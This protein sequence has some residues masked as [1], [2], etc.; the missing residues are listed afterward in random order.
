MTP[1][2]S[3]VIL[4]IVTTAGVGLAGT[5]IVAALP[6]SRPVVAAIAAPFV[7]VASLAAGVAVATRQMLI[8]DHTSQTLLIVLAA[9]APLALLVGLVL[10]RRA[11]VIEREAAAERA[12]RQRAREVEDSRRE[13]IRWLS[14]DLRTPLAGIRA[15]AE[16]AADDAAIDDPPTRIVREVDRLDAMVDDIVEL[17]RLH[18]E[19]RREITIASLDDIVSDAVA[20]VSP[21]AAAE[22]VTIEPTTLGGEVVEVE[23]RELTRAVTNI[24][25]NAVQHT[26][27]GGRVLLTTTRLDSDAV[28]SVTD[29]C[30][31]IPAA[32]LPHLLEPGWRG[33]SA[34]STRGM[35]LGL[36]IADEVARAHG[37]EVT[38][39]GTAPSAGCT[40]SLRLP[41]T[42]RGQATLG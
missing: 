9:C 29:A 10:A 28:V 41:A 31:G 17:S 40:V 20:S 24:I 6:R 13:T 35:G 37:G 15:L 16:S 34:R 5:A 1:D 11:R 23:V 21:L 39:V 19:R 27:A 4:S 42:V 8:D 2:Q 26:P 18:A 33:D 12:D 30:G 32:D 3:A 25:R 38:I 22:S 14:H 36:A 7:V